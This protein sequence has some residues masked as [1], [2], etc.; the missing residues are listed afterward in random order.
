MP[1][2]NKAHASYLAEVG[3][4]LSYTVAKLFY[5]LCEKMIWVGDAVVKVTHLVVGEAPGS[6]TQAEENMN[7][8]LSCQQFLKKIMI[9]IRDKV[10]ELKV[11][12]TPIS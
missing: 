2:W 1:L 9:H 7:R 12:G 10:L 8:W 11:E 6:H 5:I 4:E 3:V